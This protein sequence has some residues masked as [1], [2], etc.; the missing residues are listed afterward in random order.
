MGC[1]R[2]VHLRHLWVIIIDMVSQLKYHAT[3]GL[4]WE[5]LIIVKDKDTR[6]IIKAIDAWGVVKTSNIG[7]IE[8]TT[9]INPEGGIVVSLNEEETKD[10]PAGP[11]DFDVVAILPNRP[12]TPGG[13]TTVTRPVAKGT[14]IV[15]DVGTITPLEEIDYMELRL[16]QGEDYYRSFKWYDDDG[17]LATIINAYMQAAD[18]NGNKVIDL[19]WFA[20]VPD[21]TTI[22]ALPAPRR[23]YVS[24]N[25][26]NSLVLHI[27]NT[28]PVPA[29]EYQFDIFVQDTAGD[30]SRLTKG[31]LFVEASV[32]VKP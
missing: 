7:R 25:A 23:G 17:D 24:Q 18:T 22:A 4:P 2:T 12:L 9:F 1:L 26:E 30:W 19:R 27:S 13:P 11:L 16:G 10:L 15:S 3:K 20:S 8:L 21:E 6:R 28:N 32:S 14:I 29:G 5:R 31:V